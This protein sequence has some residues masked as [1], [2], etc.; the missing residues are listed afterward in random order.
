MANR[1]KGPVSI[2]DFL[3]QSPNALIRGAAQRLIDVAEKNGASVELCESGVSIRY[4]CGPGWQEPISVAWLHPGER[5]WMTD[6]E[7]LFAAPILGRCPELLPREVRKALQVWFDSFENDEF[8]DDVST[9]SLDAWAVSHEAVAQNID[10]LAGRL[11]QLLA[12]LHAIHLEDLEDVKVAEEAL[13]RIRRGEERTYS[14]EE[15]RAYLG[16]DG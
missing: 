3:A 4:P 15:V 11:E 12:E 13:E 16:L 2:E 1:R 9:V 6:R 10:A 5:R 14:D 8:A 7:F